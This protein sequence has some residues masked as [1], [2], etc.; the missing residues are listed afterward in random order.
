[1]AA[2]LKRVGAKRHRKNRCH[3]PVVHADWI[4]CINFI[5]ARKRQLRLK[6][7]KFSHSRID[8]T[9]TNKFMPRSS[10]PRPKLL[11]ELSLVRREK[12]AQW[13]VHFALNDTFSHRIILVKAESAAMNSLAPEA[14]RA[15]W[16]P[17]TAAFTQREIQTNCSLVYHF[18]SRIVRRRCKDV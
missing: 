16:A 12:L 6:P 8:S 2:A 14:E 1:M 15:N 7:Q 17:T 5:N 11:R 3:P 18:F 9:C 10:Q 4:I 13:N